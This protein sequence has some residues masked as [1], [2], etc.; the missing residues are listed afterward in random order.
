MKN[1]MM[2][3]FGSLTAKLAALLLAFG[4][5][6]SA[7]GATV[8][9]A[10]FAQLTDAVTAATAG[11]TIQLTADVNW[12]AE[13]NITKSLVFDLN[14]KTVT[15]SAADSHIKNGATV[16]FKNGNMV[17]AAASAGD[18]VLGIGAYQNGG[19]TLT[20]T[21]VKVTSD[22]SAS[23]YAAF[24]AYDAYNS[25]TNT[26]NFTNCEVVY[27]ND[28]GASG[29]IFKGS[30]GTGTF[31]FNNTKV[32]VSGNAASS[33]MANATI[34]IDNGSAFEIKDNPDANGINNCALTVNDSTLTISNNG[35][36]GIT[37]RSGA[38]CNF[39]GDSVVTIS[40]NGDGDLVLNKYGNAIVIEEDVAFTATEVKKG[41]TYSIQD[42]NGSAIELTGNS[43]VVTPGPVAKI[44]DTE[45]ATLAEALADVTKDA[46]LTWVSESAWPVA[47]PVYYNGNFYA[48][49]GTT[50]NGGGALDH[51]IAQANTDHAS[52][53][54]VALI[55]VRPGY[56]QTAGNAGAG[57]FLATYNK[58]QPF[59]SNIIIYGNNAS[60]GGEAW[61]P[62][63]T[64][65]TR[66]MS[67][68]IYNLHDGAG[69]WGQ[70]NTPYVLTATMEN[71]NNV[72]EYMVN[73]SAGS[74]ESIANVTIKNCTFG[75]RNNVVVA[76]TNPGTVV[77]DGCTFTENNNNYVVN[78][79]NK[80][81]G[82]TTATI[83]N[84]T[85]NGGGTASKGVVRVN[86]EVEG[87][88]MSG[89][90]ENLTFNDTSSAVADIQIGHATEAAD[91][92]ANV[93]YTVSGTTGVLKVFETGSTTLK[94]EGDTA[95]AAANNYSGDNVALITG[96][97]TQADPYIIAN[98]DALKAFRDRV[99]MQ[100][101]DGSSQYAGKFFKLTADIDLANENW[102]PIGSMIGDHGSFC[103]VFDGDGHTISNL[104]VQKA[105]KGL[106]FFAYTTGNAEIKNLTFNNVTVKS[107]KPTGH[108]TGSFVGGVVGDAFANTVISNVH[109]VGS[110]DI[111]GYGYVGG[112]VGH[113]YVKVYDSAVEGEGTIKG[114]MWCTGGIVGYAGEGTT[115]VRNSFV[116][117]TGTGLT[118]QAAA[119]GCGAIVGM[120]EDDSGRSPIS[121]S[122]LAA[123]NVTVGTFVGGFGTSYATYCLGYLYGG[124]SDQNLSGD[125]IVNNVTFDAQGNTEPP[126]QDAV[127]TVGNVIYFTL[128]SAVEAA[129]N[130]DATA[131]VVRNLKLKESVA[132]A[133]DTS[134]NLASKTITLGTG[135]DY[136]FVLS[137]EGTTLSLANGT[138]TVGTTGYPANYRLMSET[139]EGVTSYTAVACAAEIDGTPY[140][141]FA[142][143]IAAAD[144]ALADTGIDPV[145]TVIDATAEQTNPDWKIVGG[146]LVRKV[147]VAQIVIDNGATANKYETLAEAIDAAQAGDT[148]TLIADV[149]VN[150]QINLPVPLTIDLG[151]KTIT[152]AADNRVFKIA[153]AVGEYTFKNG[154]VNTTNPCFGLFRVDNAS[155][156]TVEGITTTNDRSGGCNFRIAGGAQVLVTNCTITATNGG[157]VY[158]EGGSTVDV[159]DSTI[160]ETGT[161]TDC[162]A[163]AFAIGEGATL[164]VHNG[165]YSGEYGAFV[166]SSGGTIK[167]LDGS[168]TGRR[169]ALESDARA[170]GNED[171]SVAD[172]LIKVSGG[173]IDGQLHEEI[174]LYNNATLTYA[175]KMLISG[176]TFLNYSATGPT[177]DNAGYEISS[178]LFD[179]QV[180]AAHC[181]EGYS[182]TT[183]P[184]ANGMYTVISDF[185]AQIVR[186]GEV[187]LPK[188]TLADMIAGAQ[189]GDTVQL[190]ADIDLSSHAR[191]ASDDIVLADITLDL[192]GKTIRGFN[193]GV[194]YS[195][196]NAVIKNGTFDFVAAEAKPNYALSIGSYADG[197]AKSTGMRLENLTVKGGINIDNADV[198]LTDVTVDQGAG[199]FYCLWVDEDN[200]ASATFVSGTINAGANATAVFGVA[201]AKA[202]TTDGTLK[203]QGGTVNANGEKLVLASGNNIQVSGGS[204]DVAVPEADCASGYIPSTETTVVDNVT[205]YTVKTGSYVA[206]NTTTGVKYETLEAAVAAASAGDTVQLLA[207]IDL[208]SHA[209]SA[210]DDIVLADITLDLNGK[211]IRGFNSG[212]RY[213]GNN[214]VIKNG[215]FDFVAAEAKPNYA[216]SIGSY[217]DGAAKSTGMRLEN[218]TVKG[219]IN[220]DNAD[221]TLTDVTVDQGAGTF[222]CLWVDEDNNASA[223]FVSGT[224]NAGANATAVFGVAKAKAGTT[225]G[226]LKI[227]GGT[228]NANGEKLVLA[229]GNH[230]QVSGG[231]FDVA[232]PEADCAD[233]YIPTAQDSGTGMYTVKQGTYV[234]QNTTTGVKYETLQAAIDAANSGDTVQLLDDIA[235][236]TLQTVDGVSKYAVGITK[237]IVL[238][239]NG[240]SITCA[241]PVL[242]GIGIK[243][244]SSEAKIDVVISNLTVNAQ[245]SEAKGIF[246][247]GNLNSLVLSN[248]N[249][250]SNGSDY[251]QPLTISGTAQDNTPTVLID[252]CYIESHPNC[253]NGYAV[254]NAVPANFTITNSTIK[255][256]ACLYA[257]PGSEGTSYTVTDSTLISKNLNAGSSNSF[258]VI[259]IEDQNVTATVTDTV[260]DV[261]G[262]DNTQA[263]AVFNNYY[264][265]GGTTTGSTVTLGDGNTVSLKEDA[266]FA[267]GSSNDGVTVGGTIAISGGTFDTAVEDQY[268]ADG[269]IPLA[270][271]TTDPVTGDPIT[272]YGVKEGT[273]V[274]AI[275]NNGHVHVKSAVTAASDGI[276]LDMWGFWGM[277]GM[278]DADGNA[279]P[280]YVSITDDTMYRDLGVPDANAAEAWVSAKYIYDNYLATGKP[281]NAYQLSYLYEDGY[282]PVA[283]YESLQ[284]ALD[285]VADGQTILIL[286]NITETV[287]DSRT[288]TDN[289]VLKNGSTRNKFAYVEISD[290]SYTV[291]FG[292]YTVTTASDNAPYRSVFDI[293]TTAG[294]TRTV[295]FTNGTITA[296]ASTINCIR[297]LALSGTPGTL[298]LNVHCMT[299]NNN[300]GWGVAIKPCAGSTIDLAGT[301]IN[302]VDG[303]NV[304]VQDNAKVVIH[305][306]TF[307]QTGG[308]GFTGDWDTCRVNVSV[309]YGGEAEI[310]GGTFTSSKYGFEVCSSGGM[311]AISNATATAGGYVLRTTGG[312]GVIVVSDGKFTGNYATAAGDTISLSGGVY[313]QKP[314]DSYAATGYAVAPNTDSATSATYPWT[315]LEVLNADI[316][317]PIEGTAG[318]PIA[319]AW[320]TNNTSVVS[321]GAPVTAANVPNIITALGEN[322]ANNMPRWQS[323]VLGLNPADA[324]AVLRLG[325]TAKDATTVTITGSVDTT[326]FPSISNVTVTFRLASRNADG[327]WSN[328]DGCTGAATPSFDVALDAVAGKVLAIFADIVTE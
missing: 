187:I 155:T 200:N 289:A 325:A 83:S 196:N 64:G 164:T 270:T 259:V 248:V 175:N 21:N 163:S 102:E 78:I 37:P 212:V 296:V 13:Q 47:T 76:S 160:A 224:I 113:G 34:N 182:P 286:T 117:G 130:G 195:G 328:V 111:E 166:C 169:Y 264:A 50:Q 6:Q 216:L 84:S 98:I 269:F 167:I 165:T 313:A 24:Y 261:S 148:V 174:Q 266:Q 181:A 211:T 49:A 285:A 73:G 186:N 31:N 309:S 179:H 178:G 136:A 129:Q 217:A 189:A 237:S 272:T 205:Y 316:I 143:A 154:T 124:N 258:G 314:A 121:G 32:T 280:K 288:E 233:G 201:K 244:A 239:G 93:S 158:A 192:N 46:P 10:T 293:A 70:H 260:I 274:A 223:T 268:C 45:Y 123:T 89:T 7:W 253:A 198:T 257:K 282:V 213:S 4:L 112:M 134:I 240:K 5:G 135:V 146:T 133:T 226:T 207:D 105:E 271:T 204:F 215:T 75:T 2:K 94:N 69:F 92:K 194:R 208:S 144:A 90:F 172:S 263:I 275:V 157:G 250:Y 115:D 245:T 203:I 96:S 312:N 290:K 159:Y 88:T 327:T 18:T 71:C 43:L 162:N 99:D 151:G 279:C 185:E 171:N 142:E 38:A 254:L 80:N 180:L 95:I 54:D 304:D 219:G 79:N 22:G 119:G 298:V 310:L 225:D 126:V 8:T 176:G 145:I 302:S 39:S 53:T 301:D 81:G 277:E 265:D 299:L 191:S 139:S 152:S 26:A 23:G 183:T 300:Q 193:S 228:V 291:D 177:A 11:D 287:Y 267:T 28:A 202:G 308:D 120:A 218:L 232:V 12:N 30:N 170:G 323:Y 229:S 63:V 252:N 59:A 315:V 17:F 125:L 44:G 48:V 103:G 281:Y 303:G 107:T 227:Q 317:Y 234:A 184:D 276:S 321:E 236:T 149:T 242:R 62:S 67:V 58:H 104:N 77:I 311:I 243:G 14:G 138:A 20:L 87:T 72:H 306:G 127:A 65:M 74:A 235:P 122:N 51:A 55:Y 56:T 35:G 15:F 294:N 61:E 52:S 110:I 305:D 29:G 156:V 116:T 319:L 85:F 262:A 106:G 278:L 36:R 295:T 97:G 101:A 173:T 161:A 140:R 284:A 241:S 206:Q 231:S 256:W 108:N 197:A 246:T 82:T 153:T 91:N 57:T 238:D 188:G 214:A 297:T 41:D 25:Q 283:K 109:V 1:T 128:P 27:K 220:I 9:V 199:T 318:V 100:K 147:Y 86:G 150:T 40:G 307:T 168:V 222:Y 3:T 273:Y 249:I 114:N 292:G 210:S 209:R 16:E 132:I 131:T 42:G 255:G 190:L 322:G 19:N 66:D 221:V 60:L 326:K 68:A 247:R 324:T 320:A 137:G 251:P 141:T 118:V 33:T 230:I